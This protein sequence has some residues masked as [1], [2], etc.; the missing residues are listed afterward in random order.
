MAT[1]VIRPLADITNPPVQRSQ[2]G[3]A[4]RFFTTIVKDDTP[5]VSGAGDFTEVVY[6]EEVNYQSV[7]RRWIAATYTPTLNASGAVFHG[8]PRKLDE[9]ISR[10]IEKDHELRYQTASDLK[11]DRQRAKRYRIGR[12]YDPAVTPD[13]VPAVTVFALHHR[14]MKTQESRRFERDRHP[15]KPTR[16]NP[17]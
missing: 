3:F 11:A 12:S 7:G 13:A 1:G 9:I 4:A 5:Q 2:Q 6:E 17:Q 16:L 10:A 8:I 15:R 14:P